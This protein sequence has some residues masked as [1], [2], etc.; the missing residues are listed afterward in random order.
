MINPHC[1]APVCSA[2]RGVIKEQPAVAI[3]T[4]P[5]KIGLAVETSAG[6]FAAGPGPKVDLSDFDVGSASQV[7]PSQESAPKFTDTPD[8]N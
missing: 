6:H 3:T 8:K 2:G 4:H 5:A 7:P 1:A